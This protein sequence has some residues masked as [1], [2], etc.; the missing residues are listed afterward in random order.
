MLRSN[1]LAPHVMPSLSLPHPAPGA[2]ALLVAWSREEHSQLHDVRAKA[3]ANLCSTHLLSADELYQQEPALQPGQHQHH[4]VLSISFL[5]HFTHTPHAHTHAGA[6][7]ALHIP[8]ERVIDSYDLVHAYAAHARANGGVVREHCQAVGGLIVQGREGE[9]HW[10]VNVQDADGQCDCICARAVINAAGLHGDS[11]DQAFLNRV[12]FHIIPRKGEFV[13]LRGCSL[14]HPLR[15]IILPFPSQRTKGVLL[16]P[17]LSGHLLIGPTAV[18]VSDRDAR[19]ARCDDATAL[20]L[21]KFA[22]QSLKLDSRES[23]AATYAGLRPATQHQ[24]YVMQ[25]HADELW[26][27]VAGIRSTG[28]SASLGI[29]EHTVQLLQRILGPLQVSSSVVHCRSLVRPCHFFSSFTLNSSAK[30]RDA[31]CTNPR[32]WLHAL[33]SSGSAPPP[34]R[35]TAPLKCKCAKQAVTIAIYC[36]CFVSRAQCSR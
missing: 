14:Q 21:L 19:T 6:L 36:D 35:P 23:V 11:V 1:E 9:R 34:P 5:L 2:G 22:R 15:H 25:A 17:T 20:H 8:G 31:P 29:A 16:T 28:V 32:R 13:V 12:S 24:D 26:V 30:A 4:A 10:R 3:A 27:T 7:G 33:P 18:D